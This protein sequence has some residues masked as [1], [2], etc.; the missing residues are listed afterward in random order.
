M[1]VHAFVE[2]LDD[3]GAS[4]S[5]DKEE[6]DF[7]DTLGESELADVHSHWLD[8][9]ETAMEMFRQRCEAMRTVSVGAG[10]SLS[11]VLEE[12]SP[13]CVDWTL[14]RQ[15][16]GNLVQCKRRHVV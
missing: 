1:T 15:R 16:Y 14:P 12:C 10:G 4:S 5:D 3:G 11:L 8:A 13:I 7:V 2:C 6:V 9:V